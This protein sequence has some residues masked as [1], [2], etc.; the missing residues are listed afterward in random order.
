MNKEIALLKKEILAMH[1]KHI[2]ENHEYIMKFEEMVKSL[3]EMLNKSYPEK[4]AVTELLS[5]LGEIQQ[6]TDK[7]LSK[8]QK[9]NVE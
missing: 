5:F 9:N 2:T 4:Q 3:G 7:T 8:N 1:K 6:L